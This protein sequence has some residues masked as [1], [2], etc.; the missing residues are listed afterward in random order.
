MIIRAA[1]PDDDDAIWTVLEPILRAGETYALPR[2]WSRD[3]MLAFWR[4]ADHDVFVVEDAG[5]IIAH[6]ALGYVDAFVM[7]RDV[8]P[9]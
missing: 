5:A 9:V 1:S 2:D 3:A 4:S 8:K 6:P 7:Y